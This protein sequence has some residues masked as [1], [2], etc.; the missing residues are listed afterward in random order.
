MQYIL[1]EIEY[2][3]YKTGLETLSELRTDRAKLLNLLVV[4]KEYPCIREEY[5]TGCELEKNPVCFRRGVYGIH[6]SKHD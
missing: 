5:C 1:D 2:L 3:N 6:G 4:A